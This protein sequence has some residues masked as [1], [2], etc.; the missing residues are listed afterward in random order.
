[1]SFLGGI[2]NRFRI[3][4]IIVIAIFCGIV[5]S[6]MHLFF[7]VSTSYYFIIL[8]FLLIGVVWGVANSG[9]IGLAIQNVKPEKV[10]SSIG[11]IATTWNVAGAMS[12]A[13]GSVLFNSNE[14][15][16]MHQ[17]LVKHNVSLTADQH[18]LIST[19]LSDPTRAYQLLDQFSLFKAQE[20]MPYFKNSFL[21]GFHVAVWFS[22]GVLA[23]GLLAS[24]I[25]IKR[26]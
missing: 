22:V 3:E 11:T 1:F 20:I 19:M 23:L 10:G 6:V 16:A 9:G 13:I 15:I 14:K 5:T 21:T 17:A 4:N 2:A 25:L 7:S 26:K 12:I 18:S 24:F 8:A